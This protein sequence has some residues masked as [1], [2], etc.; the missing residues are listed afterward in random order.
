M[1]L[2]RMSPAAQ[3]ALRTA[4]GDQGVIGRYRAKIHPH[5]VAGCSWWVGAL[6]A[7]GHGRFWI[8]P[9]QVR[10][11]A[12]FVIIAHRFGYGLEHGLEALLDAPVLAHTVCD[13]PMCQDPAHLQPSTIAQNSHQ[14]ANRRHRLGGHL[15]DRRGARVRAEQIRQALREGLDQ[16]QVLQA[17]IPAVER[18]QL[19]LW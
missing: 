5:H 13:N 16:H 11:G 10:A 15:R 17:G 7:R 1:P 8:A 3:A 18:D 6:T 2:A 19:P 9:D 14:W 12:G 4:L